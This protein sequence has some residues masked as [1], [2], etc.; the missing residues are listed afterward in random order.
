MR[1]VAKTFFVILH[2]YSNIL[3]INKVRQIENIIIDALKHQH[4]DHFMH[5]LY[6]ILSI[7]PLVGNNSTQFYF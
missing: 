2:L 6:K 1:H 5:G 4:I 3:I 7:I